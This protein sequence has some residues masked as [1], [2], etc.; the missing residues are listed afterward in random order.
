M[1]KS[2]GITYGE[3]LEQGFQVINIEGIISLGGLFGAAFAKP[4]YKNTSCGGRL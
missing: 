2:C 1:E 3:A 4:K